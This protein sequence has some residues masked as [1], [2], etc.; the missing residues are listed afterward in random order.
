MM[1]ERP[2]KRRYFFFALVLVLIVAGLIHTISSD[3]RVKKVNNPDQ[4][5]AIMENVTMVQMGPDG[6]PSHRLI[7]PEIINYQADNVTL[8][9]NPQITLYSPPGL[10]WV[11]TAKHGKASNGIEKIYLWQD[12]VV[13]RPGNKFSPPSTMTTTNFTVYPKT[14]T[15]HTDAPVRL[16]QPGMIVTAVGADADLAK[17][18]ISLLSNINGVYSNRTKK[19]A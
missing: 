4:P 9:T 5:E 12:V 10:P 2:K 14:K 18:Q 17:K 15:G 7:S 3:F 19:R 16:T 6:Y 8:S 1:S 13:H 11:I